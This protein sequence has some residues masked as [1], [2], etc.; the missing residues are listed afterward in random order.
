MRK[1]LVAFSVLGLGAGALMLSRLPPQQVHKEAGP[2]ALRGHTARFRDVTAPAEATREVMRIA[3][4]PQSTE[5]LS[6]DEIKARK[7][8]GQG[9][10]AQ[11]PEVQRKYYEQRLSGA[12]TEAKGLVDLFNSVSSDPYAEPEDVDELRL[13]LDEHNERIRRFTDALAALPK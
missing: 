7:L 5:G 8:I 9:I 11:Q 6:E 12:S 4:R 2:E 3:M 1:I 13:R 10:E